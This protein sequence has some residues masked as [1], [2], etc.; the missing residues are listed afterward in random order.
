MSPRGEPAEE[1]EEEKPFGAVMG[2]NA[3]CCPAGLGA[4]HGARPEERLGWDTGAAAS[5]TRP[6]AAGTAGGLQEALFA[7]SGLQAAGRG[8]AAPRCYLPVRVNKAARMNGAESFR[9]LCRLASLIPLYFSSQ[10]MQTHPPGCFFQPRA[11]IFWLLQQFP[12]AR[13]LLPSHGAYRTAGSA[14]RP[15]EETLRRPAASRRDG[16]MA[17]G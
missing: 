1:N 9:A 8:R 6:Y 4:K 14:S 15:S 16:K 3:S 7:G 5:R 17:L 12:A 11:S 10:A 2:S 13:S